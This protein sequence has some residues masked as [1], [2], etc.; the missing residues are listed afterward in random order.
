[1][2]VRESGE[3]L[4]SGVP[5]LFTFDGY[6]KA[7]STTSQLV[8]A[9]LANEESWVLGL[10]NDQRR[11]SS[12]QFLANVGDE[13]RRLYLQEYIR[14]WDA[15]IADIRLIK[16]NDL[17][18]S[19]DVARILSA[20]DSPLSALLKAIVKEVT[21]VE[22][23]D[24]NKTI[25]DKARSKAESTTDALRQMFSDKTGA[26]SPIATTVHPESIVDDHYA[27]LRKFVK[28]PVQGQPAPMDAMTGLINDLYQ[29]L[30][31]IEAAV[32][33][34]TTPAPSDLPN[35]V[36]AEAGHLPDPVRS[37]LTTLSQNG[38][39]Q[40]FGAARDNLSQSLAAS[41]GDFCTRATAGRYPF[42]KDS[43]KDVT[44]DDF[45]RLFAPGGM[46]D[47]FFQKNLAAYVDTSTDP[48][49]FRRVGDTQVSDSPATLAQFAR[50]QRIRDVFFR[51]GNRTAGL[52]LEFRPLE[53]DTSITQFTLDV[54]GQLVKYSHG[55]QV[56]STV[57]WP[58]PKGSTQVRLELS[59]PSPSG[60]SGQVFE[61]PWALFRMLD[62]MQMTPTQQ[63]EKFIV[64]FNV[65]GRKA[66]F[67]VVTSSVENPFRLSALE[68][69]QCP[70][71]L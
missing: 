44:Q 13:V 60:P 2:F 52:R 26:P 62:G 48:W 36:R 47:D 34:G 58:G 46:F 63:Q 6:H 56:P 67:E 11:F 35:K 55:P 23:D 20:P 29:L 14:T 39:S 22:P 50:A 9:Q 5:G 53:M 45:T 65:S 24:A 3:A 61:G 7:F 38:T 25:I 51:G 17:R 19:I 54:D 57:Q 68:Q 16:T 40:A 37:M 31:N 18:Q 42:V 71:R 30:T 21:L 49:S 41:I 1:V 64:T 43:A 59:P 66:Q 8:T 4:T 33:A 15:F 27:P 10:A 32:K 69:F 28:S 12:L 70:G